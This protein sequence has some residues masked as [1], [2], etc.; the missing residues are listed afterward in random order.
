MFNKAK[1]IKNYFADEALLLQSTQRR[2][3]KQETQTEEGILYKV[4]Y[5]KGCDI[6]ETEEIESILTSTVSEIIV[7]FD[8][9]KLDGGEIARGGS[10]IVI[11]GTMLAPKKATVAVKVIQSQMAG[12]MQEFQEELSMLYSLTHPNIISFIGVTFY[13]GA[14]MIIQDY[15]QI[16]RAHV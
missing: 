14:I 7:P 16:G 10:G 11:K 12:E 13:Q 9:I 2:K 15:C 4:F 6:Q 8:N 5:E 1:E 3:L